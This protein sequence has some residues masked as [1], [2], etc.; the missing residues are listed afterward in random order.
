M[1]TGVLLITEDYFLK[2]IPKYKVKVCKIPVPGQSRLKSLK[3]NK[4]QKAYTLSDNCTHYSIEVTPL[5]TGKKK[6]P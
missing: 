6:G 2:F 4:N 5:C 1:T 3:S